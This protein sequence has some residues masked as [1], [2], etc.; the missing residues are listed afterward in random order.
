LA[1]AE[2]SGRKLRAL[3]R[4]SDATESAT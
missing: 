2:H 4:R 1:V 3:W